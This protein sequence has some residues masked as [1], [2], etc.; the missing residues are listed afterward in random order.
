MIRI[1]LL[2]PKRWTIPKD[3]RHRLSLHYSKNLVDWCFA[4]LVANA[5]DDGQ[6]RHYGP[7]IIDG[8]DLQIIC[9]SA[10]P[11]ASNAHNADMITSHT[12]RGFRDLVY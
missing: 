7:V 10:G 9:R 1:E 3:E 2:N 5:E 12:V 11:E 4:G 6:S 8:D